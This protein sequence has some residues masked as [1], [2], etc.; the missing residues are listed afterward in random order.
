MR[1]GAVKNPP[2]YAA[3]ALPS[4][5]RGDYCRL[6]LMEVGEYGHI[7]TFQDVSGRFL[8]DFP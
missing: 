3:H 7:G 6:A 4:R 5:L 8:W 1:A 2:N